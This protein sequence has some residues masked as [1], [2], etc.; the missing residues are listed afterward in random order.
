MF[1]RLDER[2][3]RA[4][5]LDLALLA[6]LAIWCAIFHA[7]IHL[8]AYMAGICL[9]TIFLLSAITA[10]AVSIERARVFPMAVVPNAWGVWNM[11]YLVLHSRRWPLGLLIIY[12]LAWK[13]LVG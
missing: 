6:L 3:A 1:R 7:A 5:W 13:Y 4:S 10:F 2:P 9:P 11:F 8:L 12:Y